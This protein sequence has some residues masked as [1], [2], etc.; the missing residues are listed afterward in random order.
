MWWDSV[1]K[2]SEVAIF[3]SV[4]VKPKSFGKNAQEKWQQRSFSCFDSKCIFDRVQIRIIFKWRHS[5]SL[6]IGATHGG[7][8]YS[9]GWSTDYGPQR[10]KH[11]SWMKIFEWKESFV[12]KNS[13]SKYLKIKKY[14]YKYMFY[15]EGAFCSDRFLKTNL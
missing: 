6:V 8:F 13:V 15:T 14:P 5:R 10:T 9:T 1:K 11:K 2:F 7:K 4:Q 3:C 12:K